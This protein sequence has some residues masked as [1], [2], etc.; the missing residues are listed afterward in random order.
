VGVVQEAIQD[1]GGE[2]VVAEDGPPLGDDLVGS[3]QHAAA[4]VPAC[5]ELE[6]EVRTALLERQ[7]AELVDDEKLGLGVE[8]QALVELP[9]GLGARECR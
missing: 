4:L 7:V 9:F 2:D 5:D 6:E 8:G 3:N 1:G